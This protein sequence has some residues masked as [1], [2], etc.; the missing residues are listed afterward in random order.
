MSNTN[1]A[2]QDQVAQRVDPNETSWEEVKDLGIEP[3]PAGMD[4]D[5]K[6]GDQ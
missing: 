6:T 3:E 1:Q 5:D 4:P 2:A